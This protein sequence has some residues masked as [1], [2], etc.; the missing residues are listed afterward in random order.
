MNTVNVIIAITMLML[1][2]ILNQAFEDKE[3][4]SRKSYFKE[5]LTESGKSLN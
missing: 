3:S 5:A 1:A 2:I 4:G